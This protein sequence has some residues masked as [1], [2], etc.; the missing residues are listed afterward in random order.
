MT[1]RRLIQLPNGKA[2]AVLLRKLAKDKNT[3]EVTTNVPKDISSGECTI[4]TNL[5][6][7][8]SLPSLL[9][10][11]YGLSTLGMENNSLFKSQTNTVPFWTQSLN[12]ETTLLTWLMKPFNAKVQSVDGKMVTTTSN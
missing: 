1:M 11:E 2:T 4:S 9:E 3:L 8:E 10:E 6:M 12:K 5:A 7:L